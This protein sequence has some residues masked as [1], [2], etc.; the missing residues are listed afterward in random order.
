MIVLGKCLECHGTGIFHGIS[1][2]MP[3][4]ACEG[5]GTR[6]IQLP[7]KEKSCDSRDSLA[8]QH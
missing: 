1:I 3:C 8:H 7:D 6:E 2:S 5:T 4:A